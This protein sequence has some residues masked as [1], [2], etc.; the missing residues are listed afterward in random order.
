MIEYYLKSGKLKRKTPDPSESKSLFI[1][2][3]ERLEFVK[4]HTIT[5]KNS[6]FLFEDTYESLRELSQSILSKHGYKP[7]SHEATITYLFYKKI[8]SQ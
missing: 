2:A 3:I 7:Y 8:K 1:Q 4:N 5:Q 6:K